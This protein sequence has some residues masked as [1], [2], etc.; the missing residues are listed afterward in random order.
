MEMVYNYYMNKLESILSENTKLYDVNG[1]KVNRLSGMLE[2]IKIE[3]ARKIKDN[4]DNKKY[5][6][7]EFISSCD[8]LL[9]WDNNFKKELVC[10]THEYRNC[11][12]EGYDILPY[13]GNEES[14]IFFQAKIGLDIKESTS[15]DEILNDPIYKLYLYSLKVYSDIQKEEY[16][17]L[18]REDAV[19][20]Y[21]NR[22]NNY[23]DK[24]ND[25]EVRDLVI[26]DLYAL[27]EFYDDKS[28][29]DN[30]LLLFKKVNKI[31]NVPEDVT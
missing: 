25:E 8:S 9:M 11:E 29:C 18:S 26:E 17:E 30:M 10:G 22:I 2:N 14:D 27:R 19:S 7:E 1:K 31:P 6:L 16:E 13:F 20:V 12:I 15:E 21:N 5:S 24:K 28:K 23:K 3:C 4:Y